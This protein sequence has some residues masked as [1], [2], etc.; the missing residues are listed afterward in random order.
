MLHALKLCLPAL[1]PSW[2]FFDVIGPSPRLE[3]VLLGAADE[4]RDQWEEFRPR[5]ALL[6]VGTML[7]RLFWSP[8]WNE[9]LFVA[10]CV[11]RLIQDPSEDRGREILNRLRAELERGSAD[12][13]V[14][15]FL[16]FRLI[17]VSREGADLRTDIAFVSPVER[18]SGRAAA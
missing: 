1:F 4:I 5:P 14:T 7:L 8:G 10:T 18:V 16:R 17:F 11:E 15:P 6:P 3:Y 12:L 13:A 2:R 9:S